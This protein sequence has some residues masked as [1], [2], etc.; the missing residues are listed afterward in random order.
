[1][2][3]IQR[4]SNFLNL[5]RLNHS[6]RNEHLRRTSTPEEIRI[7]DP[8]LKNY[9]SRIFRGCC[10]PTDTKGTKFY[11]LGSLKDTKLLFRDSKY[12]LITLVSQSI[13]KLNTLIIIIKHRFNINQRNIGDYTEKFYLMVFKRH[14]PS[15]R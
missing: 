4:G 13:I 5:M 3:S 2:P 15:L 12:S 6:A 9:S 10:H 7:T 1:M 14:S 11:S 8:A